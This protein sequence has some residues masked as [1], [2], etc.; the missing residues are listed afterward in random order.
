MSVL[1]RILARVGERLAERRAAVP[2]AVVRAEAEA[3]PAPPDFA[4]ALARPGTSLIAEAKAASPSTSAFMASAMS[5]TVSPME[6][7]LRLPILT[8][9][10]MA[11][12]HPAR[13]RK[14]RQV[15]ST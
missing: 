5:L 15:S 8:V 9:S 3:V 10:P 13:A 11:L 6:I 2:L 1:D 14:P 4:D 7:S 12:S